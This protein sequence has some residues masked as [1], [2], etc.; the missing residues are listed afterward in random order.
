MADSNAIVAVY[1]SHSAADDA[2]REL[3]K[4]GFDMKKLSVVGKDY[5]TEDQVVG[6][7]NAGERMRHWGKLGAFWGGLWG[8]L[9]GAAFFWVPG[10]G[11]ILVGGPL[12]AWI[13][14]GLEGAA[15]VGGLSAIGAGLYSL[16]IPK[17]S[18]VEYESALKAGAF[19]VVAHGTA[20]DVAK[21][22]SILTTSKPSGLTEHVL[23]PAGAAA[24]S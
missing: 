23:E 16:G 11:P 17:D 13:I 20:E 21:A 8:L 10:I 15:V 2:V 14:A 6:Y 24:A 7:Y 22:K 9:F 18:I 3:Q 12:V 19:V 5:H 4:A 1:D